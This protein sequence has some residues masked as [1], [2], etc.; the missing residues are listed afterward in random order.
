[1]AAWPTRT[2]GSPSDQTL[3]ITVRR[4]SRRHHF[5]RDFA[6]TNRLR[7]EGHRPPPLSQAAGVTRFVDQSNA[8]VPYERSGGPVKSEN[9]PPCRGA[10]GG[11]LQVDDRKEFPTST[12]HYVAVLDHREPPI[13]DD[14]T[15][16]ANA[17]IKTRFSA[18]RRGYSRVFG[19]AAQA[20]LLAFTLAAP[21][22]STSRRIGTGRCP[23][24]RPAAMQD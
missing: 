1:M 8:G 2:A 5:D 3:R 17:L 21:T 20:L 7:A 13:T 4:M 12:S 23:D 14:P 16:S 18:V 11:M 15:S 19:I 9:G 22:S 6:L 24:H 10:R